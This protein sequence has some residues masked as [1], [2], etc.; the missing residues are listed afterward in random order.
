MEITL[1]TETWYDAAHHLKDYVGPC[2]NLHGHTYKLE[3]WTKGLVSQL[4]KTGIL[5]DFGL[6]K[7]LAQGFDHT[8]D[9]TEIMGVNSTAENQAVY[10]YSKLKDMR[11]D[12]KFKVRVYEQLQP[13][14]SWAELGDF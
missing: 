8:G 1:H 13:K 3:V 4:D 7:K 10:F 5:F 2:S 11:P 9:T 14:E 6:V 12:L